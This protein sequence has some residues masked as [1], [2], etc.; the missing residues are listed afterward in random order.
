MACLLFRLAGLL[1]PPFEKSGNPYITGR[2]DACKSSLLEFLRALFMDH[3]IGFI[4]SGNFPLS[5]IGPHTRVLVADDSSPAIFANRDFFH[6]IGS[7]RTA[8]ERKSENCESMRGGVPVAVLSN[9]NHFMDD[10][11]IFG[12]YNTRATN[13]HAIYGEFLGVIVFYT[14]TARIS[15]FIG[16][17]HRRVATRSEIRLKESSFI[18]ILLALFRF[19]YPAYQNDTS[20]ETHSDRFTFSY[21]EHAP[22]FPDDPRREKLNPASNQHRSFYLTLYEFPDHTTCHHEDDEV[23]GRYYTPY[24]NVNNKDTWDAP[25]LP[26]LDDLMDDSFYQ[27][28]VNPAATDVEQQASKRK[29][30]APPPVKKPKKKKGKTFF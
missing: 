27:G 25:P 26:D 11:R 15:R 14:T 10:P 2:P 17:P 6:I 29:S 19:R 28:Q 3:F 4:S 21:P 5:S 16:V 20:A 13:L 9:S 1:L 30:K 12:A 23:C 7:E 8:V 22:V 24:E 18:I